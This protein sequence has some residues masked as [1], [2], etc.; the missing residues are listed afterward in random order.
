MTSAISAEQPAQFIKEINKL[1]KTATSSLDHTSLTK[2]VVQQSKSLEVAR[3][4]AKRIEDPKNPLKVRYLNPKNLKLV[5]DLA[6]GKLEDDLRKLRQKQA[7]LNKAPTGN[8]DHHCKRGKRSQ[9][10]QLDTKRQRTT[11]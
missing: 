9:P 8:T 3:N 7:E 1:R 4:L 11:H 5:S 6:S 10:L 2:E